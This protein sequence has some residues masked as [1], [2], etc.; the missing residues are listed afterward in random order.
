MDEP[1]G[2]TPSRGLGE[3]PLPN[4]SVQERAR[5]AAFCHSISADRV[6]PGTSPRDCLG[7]E[8][9]GR[10]DG[11]YGGFPPQLPRH[12]QENC[13]EGINEPFAGRLSVRLAL[14][15]FEN[16]IPLAG[17]YGHNER[18]VD[19]GGVG[20]R[21]FDNWYFG[22][23]IN[24]FDGVLSGSNLNFGGAWQNCGYDGMDAP[25]TSLNSFSTAPTF[26]A[27][28]VQAYDDP[29]PVP[30]PTTCCDDA[31]R[32]RF[33][34]RRDALCETMSKDNPFLH[35][36]QAP[37]VSARISCKSQP[38]MNTRLRSASLVVSV[39]TLASF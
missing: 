3:L 22:G 31:G 15:A 32:L 26:N 33:H 39:V 24:L 27:T 21:F 38:A 35:L 36:R 12:S 19:Y 14:L 28:F 8:H 20:G 17:Y 13:L 30:E 9:R 2:A 6:P 5:A 23:T 1:S 16:T 4:F 11:P 18:T 37:R 25:C 29:G 7:R 10:P 34:R